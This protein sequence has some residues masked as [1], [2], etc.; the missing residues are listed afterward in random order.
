MLPFKRAI[1]GSLNE[2]MVIY[3]EGVINNDMNWF[4]V[5]FALGPEPEADIAF[6]F[7]LH[8]DSRN[9][10]VFNSKQSGQWGK[11]QTKISSPFKEGEYF[12]LLVM[13]LQDYYMVKVIGN[14]SYEFGHQM[15][16][17]KVTHLHVQGDVSVHSIHFIDCSST[18]IQDAAARSNLLTCN[19]PPVPYVVNLKEG[20]TIN[21]TFIIKGFIQ[22]SAYRFAINFNM[23]ETGDIA[24]HINP[25][26]K[27]GVLLSILI[28]TDC[29]EVR[30]YGKLVFHF[31]HRVENFTKINLLEITGDVLLSYVQV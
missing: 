30:N 11:E 21:R 16:F 31:Q 25:R 29:Y 1:P 24:L 6:H 4:E 15:P 13:V 20:L 7:N 14:P 23:G 12:Q 9:K 3:I 26:I 18:P 5:D 27:E 10:M 22:N 28:H 19:P 2:G 17:Q 8:F